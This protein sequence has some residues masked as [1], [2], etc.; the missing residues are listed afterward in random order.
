MVKNRYPLPISEDMFDW[1]GNAKVFSKIDLKSRY[2]QIQVRLGDVQ[3]MAFKTP[4]GLFEYF[5]M[6]FGLTNA[7]IQFV[8]MMNDLLA[9]YLD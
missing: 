6:P 7:P 1:L 2:W 9:D 8:N 5:V 3:K 4:W